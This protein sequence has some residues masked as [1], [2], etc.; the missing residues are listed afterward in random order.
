MLL[1]WYFWLSGGLGDF[2]K[3]RGKAKTPDIV[4]L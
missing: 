4:N 3:V 1:R 2:L